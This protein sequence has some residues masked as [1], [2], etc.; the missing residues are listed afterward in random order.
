MKLKYNRWVKE[1]MN[2][3]DD[4][5]AGRYTLL[6][7]PHSFKL[8]A[9]TSK[10]REGELE[11]RSKQVKLPLGRQRGKKYECEWALCLKFT[12]IVS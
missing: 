3:N 5:T 7:A 4:L 11:V 12:C 10:E 6:C 2:H 9:N 8:F 1:R